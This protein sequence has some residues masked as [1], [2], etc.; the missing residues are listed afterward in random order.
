MLH[1]DHPRHRLLEI[2][3]QDHENRRRYEKILKSVEAEYLDKINML[4]GQISQMK[5]DHDREVTELHMKLEHTKARFDNFRKC[6]K[7]HHIRN[8]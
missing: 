1:L 8:A 5:V 3:N 4:R 7:C 6:P 2:A